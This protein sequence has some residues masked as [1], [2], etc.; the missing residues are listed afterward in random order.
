M[1]REGIDGSY[2]GRKFTNYSYEKGLVSRIHKE[3]KK[4]HKNE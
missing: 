1:S 4:H 2:G 3:F